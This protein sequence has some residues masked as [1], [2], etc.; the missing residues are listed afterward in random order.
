MLRTV[1]FIF[2]ALLCAPMVRAQ[3]PPAEYVPEAAPVVETPKRDL[4]GFGGMGG[5]MGGFGGGGNPG[6]TATWY[7]SRPVAGA[8]DELSLLRQNVSLGYPVWK[9][10]RNL[11]LA[12]TGI[13]H[14][15]SATDVLLP[16]TG[17]P[18]PSDLWNINFGIA[19]MHTFDDGWK[20]GVFTSVGSASDRPFHTLDEWFFTAAGFVTIPTRSGRDQWM[21]S[22]FYSSVGSIAFP[23]PG[24]AYVWNPNE[25]WR[26]N[27]GI[28]FAVQWRPTPD[29]QFNISYVPLTNINAKGMYRMTEKL[30]LLA[31]YEF[32][33]D[34]YLLSERSNRRDRFFLLEQRVLGGTR[35]AINKYLSL[36]VQAGYSFDRRVGEG[37]SQNDISRDRL[38][39]ASV[40][41]LSVGMRVGF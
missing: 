34:A 15:L 9:D 38:S 36:D 18:F 10:E 31:G 8:G 1:L 26:I 41:F 21:L 33:S 13:R 25:E 5:G 24:V 19:G 22:L 6:Y 28:P 16:D 17:R 4:A 27:I 32:L 30:T 12:T 40:G 20:A 14:T 37:R 39:I 11:L 3:E 7:P 35:Y 29:W 2:S 23:V